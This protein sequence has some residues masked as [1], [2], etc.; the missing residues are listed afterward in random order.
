MVWFLEWALSGA[1]VRVCSLLERT[2]IKYCV[3][4]EN[5]SGEFKVCDPAAT[6]RAYYK[7]VS[8]AGSILNS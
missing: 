2:Q 3:L 5:A 7:S 1:A 6:K 4:F 8:A